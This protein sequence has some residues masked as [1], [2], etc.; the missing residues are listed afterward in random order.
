MSEEVARDLCEVFSLESLPYD[1]KPLIPTREKHYLLARAL[2]LI[3]AALSYPNS[4]VDVVY[5]PVEY[6]YGKY[7]YGTVSKSQYNKQRDQELVRY[8][9][10]LLY[11]ID[12]GLV[13]HFLF[14]RHGNSYVLMFRQTQEENKLLP[15]VELDEATMT[16]ME[17]FQNFLSANLHTF[18]DKFVEEEL[19]EKA[20][21]K[22]SRKLILPRE[23]KANIEKRNGN[24]E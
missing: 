19:M 10:S 3:G 6:Q 5:N 9:F 13:N 7:R 14:G 23:R 8:I 2:W 20:P 24:Q 18:L 12:P 4:E 21:K 16:I 1:Y 22:I 11:K 17:R 15:P